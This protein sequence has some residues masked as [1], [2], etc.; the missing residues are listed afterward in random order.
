MDNDLWQG[1]EG[2]ELRSVIGSKVLG[3]PQ[4]EPQFG[5]TQVPVSAFGTMFKSLKSILIVGIGKTEDFKVQT[6]IYSSPQKIVTITAKDNESLVK[7]IQDKKEEI[8]QIFKKADLLAVQHR[9]KKSQFNAKS[10][11][12]LQNIGIDL[13]IPKDYRLVDDTGDFLWMRQHTKPGESTNL[14]V[15][16]LPLNS[17]EDEQGQHIVSSRDTIGK[18]YI[19]GRKEGFYMITEAAYS[20][21]TFLVELDGKKT[22]ETRGKWE[23]KGDFMA[24]PFLNY[25]VVDKA[26]NRL[27]V[28][29]GF[30]YAPT[31]NKRDYMFELEAVLKTLKIK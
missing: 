14:L 23:M 18:K 1:V 12:T 13:E 10:L 17:I 27:I 19:P 3:L 15:Y 7:L 6:D 22:F 20:P 11:K 26:N 5:V 4:N 25:T 29:E 2:D 9:L 28:V 8:I 31:S 16:E 30:T 21:H 24:G